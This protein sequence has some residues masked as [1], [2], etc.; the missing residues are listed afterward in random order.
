VQASK[1]YHEFP[2]FPP[3]VEETFRRSPKGVFNED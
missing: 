3:K 2:V 1:P